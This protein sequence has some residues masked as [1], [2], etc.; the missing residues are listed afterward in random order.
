MDGATAGLTVVLG[1][2]TGVAGAGA[3]A[4]S[5]AGVWDLLDGAD[6]TSV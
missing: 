1:V 4:V 2:G 6:L 5:D 3:G